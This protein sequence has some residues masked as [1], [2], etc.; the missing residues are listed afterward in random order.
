MLCLLVD[1]QMELLIK[2]IQ[3]EMHYYHLVLQ[4]I[5]CYP[6]FGKLLNLKLMLKYNILNLKLKTLY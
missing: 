5:Q 2:I 6:E 3:Q 1:M 4:Q